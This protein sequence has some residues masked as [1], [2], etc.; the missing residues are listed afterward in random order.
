MHHRVRDILDRQQDHV[1]ALP[2]EL[3]LLDLQEAIIARKCNIKLC[4][5]GPAQA[6]YSFVEAALHRQNLAEGIATLDVVLRSLPRCCHPWV[7]SLLAT[8]R[9]R[10]EYVITNLF[11]D[12]PSK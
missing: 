3:N 8:I 2:F 11:E 1:F 9:V 4:G 10:Q 7:H 6:K 5:T 12:L